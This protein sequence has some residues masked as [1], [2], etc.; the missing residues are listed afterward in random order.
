LRAAEPE[1]SREPIAVS[2][3]VRSVTRAALRPTEGH[4]ASGVVEFTEMPDGTLAISVEI[5]ELAPGNHGLHIHEVGDCSAPDA[6]SAADHFSPDGHT[7]GGPADAIHHAGD[8]GNI[9]ADDRGIAVTKLTTSDLRL[10]GRYG[11]VGRAVIVHSSEDD[12]L[13]QPSGNSGEPAACGVVQT[14]GTPR[15]G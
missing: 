13:S 11:V 4:Q 3:V 10:M 12:F 14:S 8:L 9:V 7:H 15:T 1:V 6:S 2:R 5:A